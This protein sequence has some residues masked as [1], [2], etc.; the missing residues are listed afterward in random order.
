[1]HTKTWGPFTGRQLMVMFV[2]IVVGVVMV[3]TSVWAVSN[4]S[5]VAIEDPGTGVHASV[6]ASHRLK[7][8]DGS[9]P[10]TVDGTVN[11]QPAPASA[12]RSFATFGLQ[13]GL[14]CVRLF[15]PPRNQAIVVQS[16]TVDV[17]ADPSPGIGQT[18]EVFSDPM[19]QDLVADVNPPTIGVTPLNFG[20]GVVS[21]TGL[22]AVA[23]GSVSAEVYGFGYLIPAA[24]AGTV[25]A[26]SGR[27][28][29]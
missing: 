3:P 27:R 2:A 26:T 16:V 8:G 18:V 22:S 23:S 15:T 17:F 7:V 1:M 29:Q 10:L 24:Q 5:N 13:G 21:K 14:G 11:A 12:L 9:G 19:C 4:Y 20:P 6:D 25:I 28:R